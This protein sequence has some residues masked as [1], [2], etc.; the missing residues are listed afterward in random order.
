M[1]EEQV[2]GKA[3][4]IGSR[5]GRKK[6]E[7]EEKFRV[8]GRPDL[9]KPED[10]GRRGDESRVKQ[11]SRSAWARREE[12]VADRAESQGGDDPGVADLLGFVVG[13]RGRDAEDEE[14]G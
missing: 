3:P 1:D 5:Q 6:S 11:V 9:P 8:P 7:G 12:G 14:G 2:L 13:P 4:E 10:G